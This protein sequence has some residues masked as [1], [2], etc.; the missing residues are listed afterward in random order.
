MNGTY[1]R[2]NAWAEPRR[3]AY[4]YIY[5]CIYIYIYIYV[6]KIWKKNIGLTKGNDLHM[7][8]PHQSTTGAKQPCDTKSGISSMILIFNAWRAHWSLACLRG[9]TSTD[10]SWAV[11]Q[12]ISHIYIFTPPLCGCMASKCW[13]NHMAAFGSICLVFHGLSKDQFFSNSAEPGLHRHQ[14][15]RFIRVAQVFAEEIHP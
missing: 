12:T 9:P 5:I 1:I 10:G 11:C 6:G 15:P 3:C 2:C 13:E 7:D 8:S 4:I 14:G